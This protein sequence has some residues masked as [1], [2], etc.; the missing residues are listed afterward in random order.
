MLLPIGTDRPQVHRPVVNACL[1]FLCLVA[2]LACQ[3][4]ERTD[5]D[6]LLRLTR[7]L[8]LN[9]QDLH[10]WAFVTYAFLHADF[11]HVLGNLIILWV[12]GSSIEDRLGHIGYLMFFLAG[13]AAAGALHVAFADAP[14]IGASG[15]VAAVTGAALVLLPRMHI[16]C[17]VFFYMVGVFSIP[18]WWFV[19][20]GVAKDVFATGAGTAGRVA[21]WAHLGGYA[22]GIGVTAILLTGRIL[23]R[24]SYD[25]LS[26]LRHADRRRQIREAVVIKERIERRQAA[27]G[28]SE[29]SVQ[30]AALRSRVAERIAAQDMETAAV[31]YERLLALRPA[32]SPLIA[33]SRTQQIDLANWLFSN[34]R[35][36]AAADAYQAFASAF[37]GDTESLRAR[38]MV[39]LL[40]VR[41]LA[42]P[43]RARAMLSGLVDRLRDDDQ[44]AL[45]RHLQ[46]EAEATAPA[47]GIAT[48][49]SNPSKPARA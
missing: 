40:A 20:F 44:K 22:F 24:E 34:G 36:A 19:L 47:P 7:M 11:L 39:A 27:A 1:L 26:I 46:Q 37:V 48:T 21:T 5:P 10:P 31:E 23:S 35:H 33:L 25:L 43:A 28:P 17:L 41:F 8:A 29:L 38:L 49:G 18:A 32:D 45:A 42:Q 9:P 16:K 4:L 13:S 12:F 30:Q 2:F 15:G 14:V 3:W 6:A